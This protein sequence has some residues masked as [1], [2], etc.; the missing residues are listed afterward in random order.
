MKEI[1]FTVL[2]FF[3]LLW[4]QAQQQGTITYERKI[5]MHRRTDDAQMKAMLPEFSTSR[6]VLFFSDSVSVYKSIREEESPDPFESNGGPGPRIMIRMGPGE[7]GIL[8][9]NFAKRLILEQT[10]LADK[11]YIVDDTMNAE[12]WKL[13]EGTTVVLGHTC[14]KAT[15]KTMSGNEVTAWYADDIP[16]PAGPENFGG[17]PGAILALDRNNGEVVFTATEIRKSVDKKELAEPKTGKHISRADFQ[18]KMDEILGPPGPDGRRI[19]R[20]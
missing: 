11:N 1:L 3:Q 14:K 19:R 8:Y 15:M 16:A 20:M 18:K 10:E 9:K 2:V 6:H 4:V 12:T 17:L 5:N 7:N 13:A